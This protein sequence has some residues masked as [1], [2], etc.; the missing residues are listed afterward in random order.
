M[1]RLKQRAL[2]VVSLVL[3]A[4][5][6]FAGTNSAVLSVGTTVADQGE[7]GV[8]VTI[9][10]D[11]MTPLGASGVTFSILFDVS[12]CPHLSNLDVSNAGRT[13]GVAELSGMGCPGTGS[14]MFNI[15]GTPGS[16]VLPDGSGPIMTWVFDIGPGSP[17]GDFP[18][19]L[20]DATIT[21]GPLTIP[22]TLE[23]GQLTING[24]GTPTEPVPTDT[25]TIP[26]PTDT[27]TQVP[28][29]DIPTEVPPTDVPTEIPPTSTPTEV[30]TD[31]PTEEPTES[32][33]DGPTSTPTATAT[34]SDTPE[35]TPTPS[36]TATATETPTASN[37]PTAS[38]TPTNTPIPAPQ[39]TGGASDG[40]T[41]V[42]GT[43]AANANIEIITVPGGEV[44]GS[45]TAG[46]DGRFFVALNRPLNAPEE[47]QPSDTTNGLFGNVVSITAPPAAIPA[48]DPIGAAILIIL[49]AGGLFWRVRSARRS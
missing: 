13:T 46:S 14:A 30:S 25:A 10:A 45:A 37:T 1:S 40:S 20:S 17:T 24:T 22:T 9:S 39:I 26:V 29:T 34:A 31:T 28:P 8:E 32:P 15:T 11:T 36:N 38:D 33:T 18:L 3:F 23:N 6:A 42:N 48:V 21:S 43:A 41:A 12:L 27:P 49:M 4:A 44:L 35:D 2:S 16:E 7:T 5:T 19:T 47:I